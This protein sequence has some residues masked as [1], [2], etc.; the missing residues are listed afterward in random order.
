VIERFHFL[1]RASYSTNDTGFQVVTLTVGKRV[2][3]RSKNERNR[4]AEM[5]R[6]QS[7]I[8]PASFGDYEFVNTQDE[9]RT[10][11]VLSWKTGRSI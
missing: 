6:F 5:K 9:R 11:V 8:V 4:E 1:N 3:V 2:I 7:L 10:V